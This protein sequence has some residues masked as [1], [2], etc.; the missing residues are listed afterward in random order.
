LTRVPVAGSGVLD[1]DAGLDALGDDVALVT[2]MLAQNETGAVM[3]VA[4]LATAA[5]AH[6][7]IVHT[8]AAQAVGKI[9][10]SV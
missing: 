1:L 9:P 2:V 6:G 5:R 3:P 4:A 7:A 10:V 8:D